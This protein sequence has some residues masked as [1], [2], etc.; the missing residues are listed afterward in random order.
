M[1]RNFGIHKIV[2]VAVIACVACYLLT[3]RLL[4][5]NKTY[6]EPFIIKEPLPPIQIECRD[7]SSDTITIQ[8]MTAIDGT[9]YLVTIKNTD[10]IKMFYG[11]ETI[12][13]QKKSIMLLVKKG[14]KHGDE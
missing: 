14:E 13:I 11:F 4:S 10:M 5:T 7:P 8:E 9:F 12:N 2:W 3:P 1:K 6:E